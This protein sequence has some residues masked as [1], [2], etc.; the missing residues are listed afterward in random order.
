MSVRKRKAPKK[1]PGKRLAAALEGPDSL[2]TFSQ[3]HEQERIEFLQGVAA[4]L[5]LERERF[6]SSLVWL[7]ELA[8]R[9]ASD[10]FASTGSRG[11]PSRLTSDD[12]EL[13]TL[14][15]TL[16]RKGFTEREIALGLVAKVQPWAKQF[17]DKLKANEE[18]KPK[19][20]LT[21]DDL[22][23]QVADNLRKRFRRIAGLIEK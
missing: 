4:D 6:G 11:R 8:Y 18:K 20:R 7:F 21:S 23:K 1:E 15:I 17:A 22:K 16:K 12:L 9:L 10:Q 2:R 14:W 5:G 3:R 13:G 19:D